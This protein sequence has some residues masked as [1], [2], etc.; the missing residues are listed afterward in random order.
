MADSGHDDVVDP[1][2]R[3]GMGLSGDDADR[4]PARRLGAAARR[5]HHLV[6][7]AGDDDATALGEQAA[8]LFRG[9]HVLGAAADYRHLRSA[10][11]AMLMPWL[12]NER[13]GAGR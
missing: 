4:R 5:R 6:Q 13:Q 2:V 7:G 3:L 9:R 11:A 1:R 10:H 8:D 12:R